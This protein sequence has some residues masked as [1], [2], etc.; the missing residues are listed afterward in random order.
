[1][2][3]DQKYDQWLAA[4]R[5]AHVPDGFAHDVMRRVR[6]Q[7]RGAVSGGRRLPGGW[8]WRARL[9]LAMLLSALGLFR[10]VS[11]AV[12]LLIP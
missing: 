4:R 10:M 6:D 2:T 9:A 3:Q 1:M 5:R 7:A 12:H 8:T 11:V